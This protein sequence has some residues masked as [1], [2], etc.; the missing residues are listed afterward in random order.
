MSSKLE[1][2]IWSSDTGQRMPKFDKC[3]ISLR[4]NKGRTGI[5]DS[6]LTIMKQIW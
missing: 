3:Q 6:I 1:P 5:N 2:A 4:A